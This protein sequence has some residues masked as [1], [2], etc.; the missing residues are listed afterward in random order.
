MSVPVLVIIYINDIEEGVTGI[1]SKFADDTKIANTVASNNQ[2]KEMQSKLDGLSEWGQTWQTSFD[3]DKSSDSHRVSKRECNYIL[4]GTQR[5]SADSDV[6][7]G[8]T[9]SS[10]LKPSQLC[11][12][13]LKKAN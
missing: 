4:N 5:K 11:S 13:V 3:A 2:V 8:V 1:I 12:K 9:I 6:D 10:N 7:L